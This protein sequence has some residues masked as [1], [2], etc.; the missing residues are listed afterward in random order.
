MVHD[1]KSRPAAKP[2][3]GENKTASAPS[4]AQQKKRKLHRVTFYYKWCK[5]C[6]L[7]SAFCVKQIIQTDKN[8]LPFIANDDMDRCTGCRFCEI[9][10]PDF[11]ITIQNKYPERRHSDDRQ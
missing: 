6:G 5:S 3:V 9:H 10:C 8:G 7:C 2:E 11:A 4:T 1:T